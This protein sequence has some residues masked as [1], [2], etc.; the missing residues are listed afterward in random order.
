[1]T[2]PASLLNE[3]GAGEL[4]AEGLAYFALYERGGANFHRRV[5]QPP[6]GR[7]MLARALRTAQV[8]EH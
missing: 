2:D 5:G 8:W 1:M 3:R 7:V 4:T 6:T